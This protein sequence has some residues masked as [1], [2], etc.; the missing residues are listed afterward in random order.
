MNDQHRQAL[1]T[2]SASYATARL[3]F[4]NAIV[5]AQRAGISD[6][7]IARV[8]GYTVPMVRAVLRTPA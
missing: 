4:A 8:T 7:E 6:E 2:S 1:L 3:S 5:I